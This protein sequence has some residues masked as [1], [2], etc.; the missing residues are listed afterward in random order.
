MRYI[1]F[2]ILFG[3][4]LLWLLLTQSGHAFAACTIT[5]IMGPDGQMKQCVQCGPN[6]PMYCS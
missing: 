1:I 4:F 3:A 6:A 5:Y 2:S